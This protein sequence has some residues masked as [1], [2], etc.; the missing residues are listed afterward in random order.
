[1][2]VRVLRMPFRGIA[3]LRP[4]PKEVPLVKGQLIGSVSSGRELSFLRVEE[5]KVWVQWQIPLVEPELLE[6]ETPLVEI[7]SRERKREY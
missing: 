4:L 5:E 2:C 7:S 3:L 1:M 6:S